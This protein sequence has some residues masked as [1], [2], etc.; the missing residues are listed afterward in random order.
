MFEFL[1]FSRAKATLASPLV[2]Y[3]VKTSLKQ[4]LTQSCQSGCFVLRNVAN[5]FVMR[6]FFIKLL[7]VQ[8]YDSSLSV[9]NAFVHKSPNTTTK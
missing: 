4:K 9:E 8:T 1:Q 3:N 5:W 7:T 2:L 6:L